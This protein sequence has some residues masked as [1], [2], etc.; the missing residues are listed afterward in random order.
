M[1]GL[2]AVTVSSRWLRFGPFLLGARYR[3]R[4][5]PV[6]RRVCVGTVNDETET[7]R[8]VRWSCVPFQS[9]FVCKSCYHQPLKAD[10]V[11][12][13]AFYEGYWRE[14]HREGRHEAI[15]MPQSSMDIVC[16]ADGGHGS[17]AHTND[18]G[19]SE[20]ERKPEEL[21]ICTLGML[22]IDRLQ[23]RCSC[24]NSSPLPWLSEPCLGRCVARGHCTCGTDG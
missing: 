3:L 9:W 24:K 15:F 16:L 18:E 21:L 22:R 10:Q 12:C 13:K 4:T 20:Q 11:Q 23:D 14:A 17:L 6:L 19:V 1:C 7:T 5:T 8:N 2:L